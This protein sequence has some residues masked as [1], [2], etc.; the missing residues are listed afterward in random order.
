MRK[1]SRIIQVC[2][3]GTIVTSRIYELNKFLGHSTVA[4]HHLIVGHL[5]MYEVSRHPLIARVVSCI[6]KNSGN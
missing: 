6:F 1:E 2:L 3:A 5:T 4:E